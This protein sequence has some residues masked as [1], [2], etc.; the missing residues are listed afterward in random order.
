[1]RRLVLLLTLVAC[2]SSGK[3]AAPSPAPVTEPAAAA[4][5]KED[6]DCAVAVY[7]APTDAASCCALTCERPVVTVA[8]AARRQQAWEEVC[9]S[10]RCRPPSCEAAAPEAVCRN[11]RCVAK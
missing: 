7:D 1:M 11:E 8:E 10:M 5:C 4:E 9:S 2:N 6:S 3:P